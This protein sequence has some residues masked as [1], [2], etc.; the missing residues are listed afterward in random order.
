M[1]LLY[2]SHA[3]V[4]VSQHAQHQDPET[5]AAKWNSAVIHFI[6]Y[7]C[8]FPTVSCQNVFLDKGFTFNLQMP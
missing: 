5:E 7:T 4:T 6:I 3:S 8:D 2:V 1:V